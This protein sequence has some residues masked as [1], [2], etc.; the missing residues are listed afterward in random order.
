[1]L[2]ENSQEKAW[3]AASETL[4][5]EA[6]DRVIAHGIADSISRDIGQRRLAEAVDTEADAPTSVEP[7]ETQNNVNPETNSAESDDTLPL[8]NAAGHE[9]IKVT[10]TLL[11]GKPGS[12][13]QYATSK[14]GIER[15]YYGDDGR[16][17]KQVASCHHGH[18]KQ[19]PYGVHGEHAHDYTYDE[20]GKLI[21]RVTRELTDL[22]RKE[23]ADILW[24]N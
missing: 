18:P 1:M 17:Y 21:G 4:W 20:N 14:G 8:K 13:T 12:I 24:P 16:Q 15:N 5:Q 22:E 9:I 11:T 23:N 7:G 2:K 19:H 6:T 10:K 3:T